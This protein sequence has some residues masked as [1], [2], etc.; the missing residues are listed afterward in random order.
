MKGVKAVVILTSHGANLK[1]NRSVW[2]DILINPY[3]SL[4]YFYFA[5]PA[6]GR[7]TGNT[8]ASVRY[9]NFSWIAE[10]VLGFPEDTSVSLGKSSAFKRLPFRRK[11][12]TLWDVTCVSSFPSAHICGFVSLNA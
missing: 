2:C 4:H 6:P 1:K 3:H 11:K 9:W 8:D 5:G 10:D 7:N 12:S